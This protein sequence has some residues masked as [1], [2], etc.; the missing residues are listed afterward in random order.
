MTDPRV[1]EHL[2]K[3]VKLFS[4][5]EFP[6]MIKKAYLE[7]EGKPSENWTLLNQ[8]IQ[9]LEGNTADGRTFKA[10]IQ[11]ERHV[12]K[13]AKAFYIL[14]PI[15]RK[16]KNK[17]EEEESYTTFVASPRFRIEDT[18]GKPLPT[19]EP[20]QKPKLME[21]AEKWFSKIDYTGSKMGEYGSY[22]PQTNVLR[23]CTHDEGTFFHELA[24]KADDKNGDLETKNIDKN[25]EEYA[26]GEFV[27]QLT[28]NVLALLYGYDNTAYTGHYLASWSKSKDPKKIGK[29]IMKVLS[30]VK[31]CLDLILRESEMLEKQKEK[32]SITTEIEGRTVIVSEFD[33]KIW[34]KNTTLT[35]RQ[36][37]KFKTDFGSRMAKTEIEVRN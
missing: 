18:D 12:M 11:A 20:A 34:E 13:G 6:E 23:L 37:P 35:Q 2:D 16:Y 31:K 24:H 21:L 26:D 19:Y 8:L 5:Q 22:C 30:R 17:D 4:S 10:W 1:V 36:D 32:E 28:S 7:T 9:M 3:L 14:Q 25:S 27:A 15:L 33:K 29:K